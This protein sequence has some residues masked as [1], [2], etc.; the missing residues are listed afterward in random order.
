MRLA[1]VQVAL[2]ATLVCLALAATHLAA[3]DT[4]VVPEYGG[5]PCEAC[6]ACPE[7]ADTCKPPTPC[8]ACPACEACPPPDDRTPSGYM[9]CQE[10]LAVEELL[11]RD[12]DVP[13]LCLDLTPRCDGAEPGWCAEGE[14]TVLRRTGVGAEPTPPSLPGCVETGDAACDQQALVDCCAW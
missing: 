12:P 2:S 1:Q 13:P 7:Q 9:T 4:V 10:W 3:C 8:P 14:T 11:S 5:A 6:P